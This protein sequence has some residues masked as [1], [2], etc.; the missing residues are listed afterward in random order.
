MPLG[1]N[2]GASV[3]DRAAHEPSQSLLSRPSGEHP[4]RDEIGCPYE[5]TDKRW[6]VWHEGYQ[7]ALRWMM[8]AR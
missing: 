1:H 6:D 5:L 7:A 4:S 3:P 2:L 8:E